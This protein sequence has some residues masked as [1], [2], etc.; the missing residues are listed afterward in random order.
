MENINSYF[1]DFED[2]KFTNYDVYLY[3]IEPHTLYFIH[4]KI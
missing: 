2:W 1:E 3:D 4:N